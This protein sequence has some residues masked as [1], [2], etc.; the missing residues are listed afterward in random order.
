M[1]GISTA[2][3]PTSSVA[4]ELLGNHEGNTVR[5]P[6]AAVAQSVASSGPVAAL[7]AD[8][9]QTAFDAAARYPTSAAGLAATTVGQFFRVASASADVA[10]YVYRHD[11]G[12]VATLIEATPSVASLAAKAPAA[13]LPPLLRTADDVSGGLAVTGA[14]EKFIVPHAAGIAALEVHKVSENLFNP[15]T[16]RTGY[17]VNS[18]SGNIQGPAS[19]WACSGWIAVTPGQQISVSASTARQPEIGFFSAQSDTGASV[20]VFSGVTGD[21]TVTVPAGAAWMAISVQSPSYPQPTQIMINVG[22]VLPFKP[23]GKSADL[24]GRA[25]SADAL[26]AV[27]EF[28]I[29][30]NLLNIAAI[31]VDRY[32]ST[33]GS[34]KTASGGWAASPFIPVEAGKSYTINADGLRSQL[35]GFF[36]SMADSGASVG[37]AG[38]NVNG[39]GPQTVVAPAGALYMVFS[40][41]S[42]AIPIPA[43]FRVSEGAVDLP[44][45]P[46]VNRWMIKSEAL[47]DA[48]STL[49]HATLTIS[50]DGVGSI[51]S[52]RAGYVVRTDMVIPPNQALVFDGARYAVRAHPIGNWLNGVQVRVTGDD[53]APDSNY[54]DLRGGNHGYLLGRCTAA[55]HGKTAADE[56]SRWIVGSVAAVLVKV[57]SSSVLLMAAEASNGGPPAGSVVH[58]SGA[59]NT[60]GF[61]IS[62]VTSEQFYPPHA[63]FTQRVL[64]DGIEVGTAQGV[65]AYEDSVQIVESC[66]IIPRADIIAHWIANGGASGGY[67]VSGTPE[68]TM[69][70][71]WHF[72]RYGQCAVLRDWLVLRPATALTRVWGMQAQRAGSPVEYYVPGAKPIMVG[73]SPISYAL[74]A[75]SA[76]TLGGNAAEF[77]AADFDDA[78]AG[79]VV[80]S[81][82]S[83][84]VFAMGFLPI[85]DAALAVRPSRV[86]TQALRIAATT[87]KLYPQVVNDGVTTRATGWRVQMVGY[88]CLVPRNSERTSFYSITLP[89]GET[90]IEAHWHD[91]A[92]LDRLPIHPDH[93]GRRYEVVLTRNAALTDGIISGSLPVIVSAAGDH[94][95]VLIRLV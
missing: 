74:K 94:G 10:S 23:F 69:S 44:W 95:F 43:E 19:G 49:S 20:G 40:V 70:T 65:W 55:G 25:A 15:A 87:G 76:L 52:D 90:W 42:N 22:A 80:Q 21:R 60:A 7:L 28:V 86:T 85:G 58:V 77:A 37:M 88:R 79:A 64:V 46:F 9:S 29:S 54:G 32:L 83:D 36:S 18:A 5:V 17:Y 62:A 34:I 12:P 93:I 11:A 2:N 81:L 59:A 4:D 8:V 27:V 67:N 39:S 30:K 47:P 78:R 73:G 56:G 6:I 82:W 50:A 51:Q 57:V 31:R 84:K 3:L 48:T 1:T 68:Y 45:E 14:G 24:V 63:N 61:A 33:N 38:S 53:P 66:D 72:D 92:A 26:D 71:T 16:V 89:G 75:S 91:K 41:S 13:A 35:V